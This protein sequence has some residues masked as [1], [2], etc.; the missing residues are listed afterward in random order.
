MLPAVQSVQKR[1]QHVIHGGE[2]RTLLMQGSCD[3]CFTALGSVSNTA[4]LWQESIRQPCFFVHVWTI[5]WH[6]TPV[7]RLCTVGNLHPG[8]LC[9]HVKNNFTHVSRS[10]YHRPSLEVLD[11]NTIPLPCWEGACR[12]RK[13]S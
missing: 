8:V 3:T 11:T 5:D 1:Q 2:F 9:L 10:E 12:T 6:S 7:Y 4:A 13:I